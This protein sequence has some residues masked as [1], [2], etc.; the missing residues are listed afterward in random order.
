ME[1]TTRRKKEILQDI[2]NKYTFEIYEYHKIYN[3]KGVDVLALPHFWM[4][5]NEADVNPFRDHNTNLRGIYHTQYSTLNITGESSTSG[6]SLQ[7][8]LNGFT[9]KVIITEK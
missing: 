3:G 9:H 5:I 2:L 7:S 4:E 1:T 6:Y 8:K